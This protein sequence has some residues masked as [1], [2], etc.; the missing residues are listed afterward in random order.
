MKYYKIIEFFYK[1]FIKKYKFEIIVEK[2]IIC[3][4]F[5]TL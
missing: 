2:S 5:L 4:N 3:Y 1:Y